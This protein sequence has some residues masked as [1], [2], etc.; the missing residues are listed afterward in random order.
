MRA[1]NATASEASIARCPN[2][3][4]RLRGAAAVSATSFSLRSVLP[5]LRVTVVAGG[6]DSIIAGAGAFTFSLSFSCACARAS[7]VWCSASR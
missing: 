3:A 5:R 4:A 7:R 6:A 1:T 2:A